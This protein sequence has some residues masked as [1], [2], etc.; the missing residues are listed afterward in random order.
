MK[1]VTFEFLANINLKVVNRRIFETHLI[2]K[3]QDNLTWA[4]L[5]IPSYFTEDFKFIE[6]EIN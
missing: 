4:K 2:P 3:N 5:N 6:I 1:I